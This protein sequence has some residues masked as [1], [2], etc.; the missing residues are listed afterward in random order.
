[1]KIILIIKALASVKKLE[2][3]YL[4]EVSSSKKDCIKIFPLWL[5]KSGYGN[6]GFTFVWFGGLLLYS[7]KHC[8]AQERAHKSSE[9]FYRN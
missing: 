6:G 1:M 2:F 3:I 5:C 4:F 7:H 8:L 9:A